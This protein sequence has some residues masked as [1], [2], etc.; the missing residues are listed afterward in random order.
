MPG[1]D[2]PN[3]RGLAG[4]IFSRLLVIQQPVYRHTSKIGAAL[5]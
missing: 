4:E 5:D 2:R 3:R 1:V